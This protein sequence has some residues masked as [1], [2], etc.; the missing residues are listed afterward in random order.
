MKYLLIVSLFFPALLQVQ[1][2]P[3][4]CSGMIL[5]KTD[6]TAAEFRQLNPVL[7]DKKNR[8][9]IPYMEPGWTPMTAAGFYTLMTLYNTVSKK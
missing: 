8:L 1:H 9:L 7:A 6:V 5:L 2:C 4:V 3:W